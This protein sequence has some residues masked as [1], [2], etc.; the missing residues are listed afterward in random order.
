[1]AGHFP[2]LGKGKRYGGAH[3]SIAAFFEHRGL[4]V[5]LQEKYYRWWYEWAKDFVQHDQDL[6]VAKAVEFSR[7]PYGQHAFH[8]F[9]LHDKMWGTAL[10]DLGDFIR[11]VILPRMDDA[12][13]HRLEHEHDAMLDELEEEAEQLPRQPP[14]EVGYFR[15]V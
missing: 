4:G 14:P 12:A 3:T 13:L 2:F 9:H 15:H 11:E 7:Y 5:S 10:A 6:S 1:M 8:N